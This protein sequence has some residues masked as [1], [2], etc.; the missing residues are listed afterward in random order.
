[1]WKHFIELGPWQKGGS[2]EEAMAETIFQK[3]KTRLGKCGKFFK[4]SANGELFEVT[5][6]AAHLSEYLALI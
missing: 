6:D 3:L 5:N 1:M 2:G 4:K